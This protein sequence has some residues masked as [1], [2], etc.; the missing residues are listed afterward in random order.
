MS[1]GEPAVGGGAPGF[2]TT[3][4]SRVLLAGE[5]AA[6]GHATALE[7]LCAQY[8][9][10]LY[11]YARRRGADAEDARDQTQAF[12]AK[13]L[14]RRDLSVADPSRG[15]FRTFLL[16][17]MKNFLA[18]AWRK[19]NA[20]KR[21]GGVDVLPFDFDSGEESYRREP[22]HEL[23][24][25]AIFERRWA[26]GVLDR[27]LSDLERR[28]A[29]AGEGEFFAAARAYVGGGDDAAPYAELAARLGRSEG[30]LRTAVSRL[31]ARFGE[32]LRARVADTVDDEADVPDELHRLIDALGNPPRGR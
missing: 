15:R 14:E 30:A 2:R 16:T 10:P 23:S 25:D 22:F 4:W 26:L 28:Y 24:A 9:Y 6:D 27:A 12:F 20:R 19:E 7:E 11:A 31:R 3:R 17:A 13:L 1:S 8:W 29:E 18:S 32:R 21:G 5:Q